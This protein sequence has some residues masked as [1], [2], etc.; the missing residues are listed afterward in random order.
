M[1][2][3]P[4]AD[5]LNLGMLQSEVAR[6]LER[7][8]HCGV[9]TGPLDGLDYAPPVEVQDEPDRFLVTAELPGV[10]LSA[11]EVS[12]TGTTLTIQ[13]E[14]PPAPGSA[15]AGDPGCTQAVLLESGRR[16]GRFR[17]TIRLPEAV[18]SEETSA[19]MV[20]GVLEVS[21]PKAVGG[22]PRSV[23]VTV[24]DEASCRSSPPAESDG[25]PGV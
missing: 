19:R 24:R 10:D 21:I 8:W 25:R 2:L 22:E 4:L 15:A 20:Q 9:S 7:L 11:L 1:P 18:R 12:I 6:A 17:R 3:N 13:G 16:Y 23:R 14:K 5:R